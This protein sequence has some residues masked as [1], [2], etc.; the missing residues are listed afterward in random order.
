MRP[1]P[2]DEAIPK[3]PQQRE[4][5]TIILED[6]NQYSGE[7]SDIRIKRDTIPN[8][9]YAYDLRESDEGGKV[10]QVQYSVLVN[11]FGT[12]ITKEPI[13]GI[14]DGPSIKDWWFERS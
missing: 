3:N 4:I 8:N 11:Y 14:E 9:M 7:F 12:I 2:Y 13:K 1:V 6:N 5:L 10:C